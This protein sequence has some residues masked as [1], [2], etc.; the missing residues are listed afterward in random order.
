MKTIATLS[1]VACLA[2]EATSKPHSTPKR[3]HLC[4]KFSYESPEVPSWAKKNFVVVVVIVNVVVVVAVV[5]SLHHWYS[6]RKVDQGLI[7]YENFSDKSFLFQNKNK[8]NAGQS[9]YG[10]KNSMLASGPRFNCY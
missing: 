7:R 4:L 1:R 3:V 8:E 6:N 5:A 9:L 10:R 2:S